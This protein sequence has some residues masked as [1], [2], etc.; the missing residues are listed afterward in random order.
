MSAQPIDLKSP[1]V[2]MIGVQIFKIM[3]KEGIT[4]TDMLNCFALFTSFVIKFA[5]KD[6]DKELILYDNYIKL[7][8]ELMEITPKVR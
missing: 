7:L 8:G 1:Q 3:E 5:T 6:D 2:A 4:P